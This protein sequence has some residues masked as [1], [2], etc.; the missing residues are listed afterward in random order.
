MNHSPVTIEAGEIPIL[1]ESDNQGLIK[2]LRLLCS[3][4]ITNKDSLYQLEVRV[5]PGTGRHINKTPFSL[6]FS[7]GVYRVISEEFE[8]YLDIDR[9]YGRI[10]IYVY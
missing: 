9:Q 8:T 2:K 5:S 7:D 10:S 3:P 4:F 1:I 6:S